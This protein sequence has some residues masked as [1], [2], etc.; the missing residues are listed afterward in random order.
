MEKDNFSNRGENDEAVFDRFSDYNTLKRMYFGR[1]TVC[2][3][4]VDHNTKER[5][6]QTKT[7]Y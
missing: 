5:Y 1:S 7:P 3:Y 2:H 4:A 6:F